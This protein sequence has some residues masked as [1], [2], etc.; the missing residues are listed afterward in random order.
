LSFAQRIK[1]TLPEPLQA[2]ISIEKEKDTPDFKYNDE[3]APFSA[4]GKE[5]AG[6]IRRKAPDSEIAAIFESVEQQA[7]D[8]G[9]PESSLASTDVFVTSICFVGSKSLSHVLS[10][11]ERCKDR[12]LAIGAVF[13]TSR[14]QIIASV[15]DYW[16]FQKGV[17][18]NIVDKL[19]NYTILSPTSVVEWTLVEH[20]ERGTILSEAWAYELISATLGKVT[21]RV[22]QIVGALRRPGLPDDQVALLRETLEREMGD[23][24]SLF[25]LVEDSLVGFRDGNQDMMMGADSQSGREVTLIGTWVQRWARVFQRKYAVEES[26]IKE[27]LAKPLPEL[28]PEE[29]KEVKV[30]ELKEGPHVNGQNGLGGSGHELDTDGIE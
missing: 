18:I 3:S 4:E 11:I 24:K 10:C 16:R 15:M 27:E 13:P 1:G 29:V 28:E 20:A 17:G 7:R 19:L 14:R 5:M 25:G 2:L 21:G 26:W 8:S 22:R 9:Y 30:E 6:L 23:M 12:L